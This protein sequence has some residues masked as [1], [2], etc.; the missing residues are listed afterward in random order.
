MTRSALR[1]VGAGLVLAGLVACGESAEPTRTSGRSADG[2]GPATLPASFVDAQWVAT[3]EHLVDPLGG[4]PDGTTVV[5]VEAATGGVDSVP[6]PASLTRWASPVASTSGRRSVVVAFSSAVGVAPEDGPPSSEQRVDHVATTHRLDPALG[7]WTDLALPDGLAGD[8]AVR[9]AE[10]AT[11][12]DDGA[13]AL[14]RVGEEESVLVTVGDDTEEWTEVARWP[15]AS[16]PSPTITGGAGCAT[17]THWWRMESLTTGEVESGSVSD[18]TTSHRVVSVDL[19]TGEERAVPP[20]DDVA[21]E[22]GAPSLVLGCGRRVPALATGPFE[23]A[24]RVLVPVDGEWVDRTPAGIG[25]ALVTDPVGSAPTAGPA[26][27]FLVA[28]EAR[29]DDEDRAEVVVV[30]DPPRPATR[31]DANVHARSV[32]WRGRST[33]LLVVGPADRSE[34]TAPLERVRI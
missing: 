18:G 24:A 13:A 2:D 7:R 16:A 22:E 27:T 5:T 30:D 6:R 10:L 11:V 32:G 9:V 14:L 26:F 21:R 29:G 17:D 34:G 28:A 3:D 4:D 12:G 15:R 31:L 23:G 25:D 19:A 1:A 8:P 33:E 20:P